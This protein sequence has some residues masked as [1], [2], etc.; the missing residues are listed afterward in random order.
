MTTKNTTQAITK[1]AETLEFKALSR[2]PEKI[3]AALQTAL[4]NDKIQIRDF[5]EVRVPS[6]ANAIFWTLQSSSGPQSL[7]AIEG[8]VIWQTPTQAL[9]LQDL[10]DARKTG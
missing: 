9:W 1:Q 10:D 3:R 4:G 5:K 2:A 8:V 6:G 7:K